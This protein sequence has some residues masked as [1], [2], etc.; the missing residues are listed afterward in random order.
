MD[1]DKQDRYSQLM[2]AAKDAAFEAA[3]AMDRGDV[4]TWNE[5]QDRATALR[6]EARKAQEHTRTQAGEEGQSEGRLLIACRHLRHPNHHGTKTMGKFTDHLKS[7][8]AIKAS[9]GMNPNVFMPVITQAD[10]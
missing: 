9:M 7:F 8:I 10:S 2:Q 4:K 5:L 3:E 6:K 1:N